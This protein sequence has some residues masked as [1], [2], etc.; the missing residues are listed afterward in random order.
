MNILTVSPSPHVKDNMSTQRIMLCVIASLLPAVI[1]SGIIFGL[2]A[3][4]LIAVCILSCIIFEAV[5]RIIMKK[6][7]TIGDLSAVLTGL[8]LALNLPVTLPFW[9]AVIGCFVAIVIVKQLFGGLG[10]NFANPAIVGRIVLML[11]FTS[12]MTTWAVPQYWKENGKEI[13]TSATPL[14]TETASYKDLFLGY[15]GGCLGETLCAGTFNRRYLLNCQKNHFSCNT[16]CIYRYCC[17]A[18]SY[19]RKRRTVSGTC[20]RSYSGCVLHG[21]RLR[22]NSCYSNRKAYFLELVCG[23]I[24]FLIRQFG[25][26]PEGVSFSILL[27]NIVTP[28]IDRFT[29]TKPIGAVKEA[30]EK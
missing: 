3:L 29:M 26:Y 16:N 20:R 4:M 9:Q 23:I 12:N 6:E 27:M 18:E 10:Q 24:T 1:A 30:K 15:T 19:R 2:R 14:V 28:Y 22:Y 13:V 11:S 7:Q 21:D 25:D 17:F 8:L 5:T